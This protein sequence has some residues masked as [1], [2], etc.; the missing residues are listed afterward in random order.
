M[1]YNYRLHCLILNNR[2]RTIYPPTAQAGQDWPHRDKACSCKCTARRG[3]E[4]EGGGRARNPQIL[5][6]ACLLEILQHLSQRGRRLWRGQKGL[7]GG[8]SSL[9]EKHQDGQQLPHS[10]PT[11]RLESHASGFRSS[12]G[13]SSGVAGRPSLQG[14]WCTF[15][16][17]LCGRRTQKKWWNYLLHS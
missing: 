6:L 7:P 2:F 9:W 15:D 3:R 14:S 11:A 17:Y 5:R 10:V 8:T 4:R 12:R 13:Q 16:I 1:T